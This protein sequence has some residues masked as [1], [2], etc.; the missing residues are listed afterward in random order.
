[1]TELQY[2]DVCNMTRIGAALDILNSVIRYGIAAEDG[3]SIQ[4]AINNLFKVLVEHSDRTKIDPT[5]DNNEGEG[6]E[7]EG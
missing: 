7:D 1:M 6:N 5:E 2:N 3:M 4:P